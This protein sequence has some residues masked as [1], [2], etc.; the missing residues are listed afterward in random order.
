[1]SE[2]AMAPVVP[3]PKCLV[4]CIITKKEHSC[5]TEEIIV[6]LLRNGSRAQSLF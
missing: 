6:F 5:N 1:M 4:S 2:W 3:F